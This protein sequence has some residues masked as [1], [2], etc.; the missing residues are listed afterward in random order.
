MP[1]A[2][3]DAA[4]VAPAAVTRYA[5]AVNAIAADIAAELDAGRLSGDAAWTAAEEALARHRRAGPQRWVFD[6]IAPL[7]ASA[8]VLDALDRRGDGSR[9]W[10]Q[11]SVA[12]ASAAVVRYDVF[13]RLMELRKLVE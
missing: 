2:L 9:E 13:R 7:V 12:F 3:P 8:N 5:I 10:L 1:D 11:G 4:P 6:G